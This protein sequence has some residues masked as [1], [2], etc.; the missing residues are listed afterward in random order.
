[1]QPEGRTEGSRSR[2]AIHFSCLKRYPAVPVS[3]GWLAPKGLGTPRRPRL[4]NVLLLK[5]GNS[6]F[7]TTEKILDH[8]VVADKVNSQEF[9]KKRW[10]T[11]KLIHNYLT[12]Y[13]QRP[14]DRAKFIF[15]IINLKGML[16]KIRIPGISC[17]G[18]KFGGEIALIW[19]ATRNPYQMG[20]IISENP[21]E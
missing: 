17:T 16:W 19:S 21:C 10:I 20:R 2:N 4:S 14:V 8:D 1:M 6:S 18:P 9:I 12:G 3:L 13:P 15:R 5:T 11:A 7:V